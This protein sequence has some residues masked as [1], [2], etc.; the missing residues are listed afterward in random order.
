MTLRQDGIPAGEMKEM[1]TAGW[2]VSFD[3]LAESLK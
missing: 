2:S 1:T 3:K